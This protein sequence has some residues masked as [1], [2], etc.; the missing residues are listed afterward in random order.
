MDLY[1]AAKPSLTIKRR[2]NA[3][4][5]KVFSAW[6]DAAKMK[7]W[8]GPG[9]IS[10]KHVESDPRAGGRYRIIMQA[11][12]GEEFDVSGI[13]REVIAGERLVYTWA[14]TA[15]PEPATLVTVTF[16]PNGTGTLLTLTHEQF[17][18]DAVRDSH[19]DGWTG[20]LVKLENYLT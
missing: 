19:T 1:V 8:M 10:A 15:T 18:D 12:S 11:P 17:P 13:Y 20:A 4:P 3:A 2:F 5:E 9:Q 14:G 16:Q 6:T 7:K